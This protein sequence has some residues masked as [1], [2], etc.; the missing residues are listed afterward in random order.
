[1]PSFLVAPLVVAESDFVSTGPE[2]L[3][4]LSAARH[5]IRIVPA[6]L[7]VPAFTVHLTWH[8]RLDNDP[9]HQWLRGVIA[10]VSASI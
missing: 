6:P 9:A 7:P 3:A 2:R 10:R 5:P 4:R 1:V 8:A